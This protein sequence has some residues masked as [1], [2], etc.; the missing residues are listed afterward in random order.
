MTYSEGQREQ[1]KRRHK[2]KNL[3]D[4]DDEHPDHSKHVDQLRAT[5]L[6]DNFDEASKHQRA[7]V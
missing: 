4:S 1:N 2:M 7:K 6:N 5:M 3:K